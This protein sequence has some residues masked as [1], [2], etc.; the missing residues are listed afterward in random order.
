MRNG[1][2][3][4]VDRAKYQK[5][6]DQRV[7]SNWCICN[8]FSGML[9][10]IKKTWCDKES[11]GLAAIKSSLQSLI[12][13]S[14]VL[15]AVYQLPSPL[16]AFVPFGPKMSGLNLLFTW[17]FFFQ[18]LFFLNWVKKGQKS[19]LRIFFY[20]KPESQEYENGSAARNLQ[21]QM[22]RAGIPA[23]YQ[24]LLSWRF[25]NGKSTASSS[26][27]IR[28]SSASVRFANL[29]KLQFKTNLIKIALFSLLSF[30]F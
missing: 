11:T 6:E 18:A 10:Y 16:F 20:A 12:R 7:K 26:A 5:R 1:A 3:S 8:S 27:K 15:L 21:W 29:S 17:P 2:I 9:L 28:I 4:N 23:F 14:W 25:I 22:S 24:K 30:L 13:P 19:P